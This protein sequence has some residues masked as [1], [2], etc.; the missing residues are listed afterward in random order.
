MLK[1]DRVFLQNIM[2]EEKD[3]LKKCVPRFYGDLFKM[4]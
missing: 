2:E 4:L 1:A 3:E